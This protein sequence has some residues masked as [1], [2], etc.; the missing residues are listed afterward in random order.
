MKL[1]AQTLC[2]LM[3]NFHFPS[4]FTSLLPVSS[5]IRGKPPQFRNVPAAII[6]NCILNI[7]GK[8]GIS[9]E[10]FFRNLAVI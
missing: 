8:F 7:D 9:R 2:R 3:K 4:L 10:M 5:Q 6:Q 1:K